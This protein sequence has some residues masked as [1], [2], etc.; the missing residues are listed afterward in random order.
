MDF[1]HFLVPLRCSFRLEKLTDRWE[2]AMFTEECEIGCAGETPE[3]AMSRLFKQLNGIATQWSK[4]ISSCNSVLDSQSSQ[5]HGLCPTLR[6][7]L[8]P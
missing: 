3:E 7:E 8:K 2:S 1:K 6:S 4:T 5:A